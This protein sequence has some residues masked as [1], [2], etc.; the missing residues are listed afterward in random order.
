ML[1]NTHDLPIHFGLRNRYRTLEE[2]RGKQGVEWE[3]FC[4]VV[5]LH[6]SNESLCEAIHRCLSTHFNLKISARAT[7]KR[8]SLNKSVAFGTCNK[9][10]QPNEVSR[11]MLLVLR[12]HSL[13][14]LLP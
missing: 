11:S 2:I 4:V 12:E 13:P 1:G 7:R 6:V 3:V 5:L 14:I 10:W 9:N 8:A